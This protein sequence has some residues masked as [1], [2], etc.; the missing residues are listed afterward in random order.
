MQHKLSDLD[1]LRV[2]LFKEIA[3]IIRQHNKTRTLRDIAYLL[4]VSR[5]T[6][7]FFNTNK[8]TLLSL[9]SIL[10]IAPSVG[11]FYDIHL[12]NRSN[13]NAIKIFYDFHYDEK[14]DKIAQQNKQGK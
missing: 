10:A 7:T 3:D 12:S 9:K 6:V 8:H 5:S 2:L 13:S 4:G 14:F 11:V 1:G